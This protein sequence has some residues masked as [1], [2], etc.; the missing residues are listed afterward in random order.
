MNETAEQQ[1]TSS[2]ITFA[3]AFIV[4]GSLSHISAS[5]N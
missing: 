2:W 4:L 3:S 5:A 1:G